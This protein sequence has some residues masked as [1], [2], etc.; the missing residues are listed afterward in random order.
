MVIAVLGR[1]TP[2]LSFWIAGSF[3]LVILPMK[4][5]ARVG[6]SMCSRF[7]TPGRLY[8]TDV[9][10][11]AQ[12]IWTQPLQAVNWSGESG[13]SLAPKSPARPVGALIPPL[14]PIALYTRV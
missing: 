3:Q 4:M 8:I 2:L 9:A 7:F 14:E 1:A 5:L 12:G 6:P 10:A 13:A 11:S